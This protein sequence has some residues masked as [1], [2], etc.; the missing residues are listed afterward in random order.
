[1]EFDHLAVAADTL[2]AAVAH[3]ED[4]L[5][6]P[7]QPG[8]SHAVFGT[9][10][11]LLGLADGLYLE[12]IAID[13]AATPRHSPRWFDL[14]RRTGPARITNW[15]CRCDD[16]AAA[17]DSAPQGAGEI[18]DLQRGNLS[19]QMAVPA[20]GVLPFDNMFPALMQWRSPHP[21]A[22]LI[23]QGCRLRRLHLSHPEAAALRATLPLSDTRIEVVT[24]LAGFEAEFDTPHG[25]RVLR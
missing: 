20:D 1:M 24:G 12:A 7:M 15:I 23:Q 5:G 16:L 11:Q 4:S 2:D 9:H 19:W 8:G 10:N 21:A 14:D 6:V 3:V 25:V 17:L 22:A 18:V 13:P